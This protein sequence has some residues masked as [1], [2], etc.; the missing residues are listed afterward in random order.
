MKFGQKLPKDVE[1]K[2]TDYID[3]VKKIKWFFYQSHSAL[4]NGFISDWYC[5]RKVY[6]GNPGKQIAISERG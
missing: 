4:R 2:L 6:R 5:E 1:K 3:R